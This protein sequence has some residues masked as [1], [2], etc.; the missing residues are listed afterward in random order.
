M[1][2]KIIRRIS[3]FT[4]LFLVVFSISVS[5]YDLSYIDED[6]NTDEILNTIPDELN[7]HLPNEIFEEDNISKVAEKFSF[8]NLINYILS[9][10]KKL[11]PSVFKNLSSL[12][13]FIILCSLLNASK[14]AFASDMF[15]KTIEY[16]SILGIAI[17]TYGYL[18]EI[19]EKT[20]SYLNAMDT[21]INSLLP[22]MALLFT[23]GGNISTAVTSSYGMAFTITFINTVLQYVLVPVLNIC[24]G[25]CIASRLSGFSGINEITKTVKKIITIILVAIVTLFSIYLMFKSNLSLATDGITV[26][27]IKFAGSF[28]PVI[29]GALGETVRSV[30]SGLSVIK[31]SVGYVGIIVVLI[32]TLPTLLYLTANKISMDLMSSF[33]KMLGCTKEGEFLEEFSSLINFSLAVTLCVGILFVFELT[34]FISISPALAGA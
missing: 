14:N 33:S 7:E 15:A 17:I 1:N 24:F 16:I 30:V 20:D 22:T 23:M 32:I 19:I 31:N 8:S 4:L 11:I 6:V 27:T 13:I 25:L 18:N 9:V 5:A 29:G 12:F 3:I 21:V 28:V 34:I 26:R 2:K 10:I